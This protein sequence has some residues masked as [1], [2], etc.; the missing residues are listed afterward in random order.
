MR[1]LEAD[2]SRCLGNHGGDQVA[3]LRNVPLSIAEP[4]EVRANDIIPVD[5]EGL[6]EC[7]VRG[8]HA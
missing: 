1:H 2:N 8:G 5:P 7:I 4:K 3:K 6:D